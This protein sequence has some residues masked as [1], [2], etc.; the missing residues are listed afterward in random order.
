M[1]LQNEH[2]IHSIEEIGRGMTAVVLE[3]LKTR[4]IMFL[5]AF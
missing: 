5:R 1:D 4:Q 2:K 3:N